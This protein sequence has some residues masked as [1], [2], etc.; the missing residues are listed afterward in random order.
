M[1]G[2]RTD[3]ATKS[4][5]RIRWLQVIHDPHFRHITKNQSDQQGVTKLKY[6]NKTDYQQLIKVTEL[7]GVWTQE[8]RL[9]GLDIM[10]YYNLSQLAT[11][12][13]MPHYRL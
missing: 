5:S 11:D 9:G 1:I 7:W 2:F 13:E 8:S 10:R 3:I 6:A 4:I 12:S